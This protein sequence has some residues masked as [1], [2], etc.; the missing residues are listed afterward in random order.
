MNDDTRRVNLAIHGWWGAGKSWF[1]D[2]APG[3]RLV[4][5]AEGGVGDTPSN[6][7][8]WNPQTEDLP[9]NIGPDDSVVVDVTS[10]AD[11]DLV[12]QLI[13]SGNHP[14]N[15]VVMDSLTEIQK[16]LKE[17]LSAGPEAVFDQ[18][19]WGKLLNSMEYLIRKLRDQTRRTAKRRINVVIITG[20]DEE[21]IP[22][23][24]MFQGGLRKS[25]AGFF[26]IVG[27]LT[28]TRN[29]DGEIGRTL[30]LQPDGVAV[31][32]CRLHNVAV[33]HPNGQMPNPT[34][35]EILRLANGE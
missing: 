8:P 26:D 34:V 24:P 23:P 13:A 31:A 5:D 6:K 2:T 12:M 19:S 16:Q 3:P 9:A 27:Y 10:W 7:I 32:K 15:S 21:M 30:Q 29:A 1:A 28:T 20:T 25:Y 14:F 17:R 33:A 22:K 35:G 11:L 18:Q 4:L